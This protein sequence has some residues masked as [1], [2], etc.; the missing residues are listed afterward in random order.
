[1]RTF[2]PVDRKALEAGLKRLKLRCL[3]ETLD[4]LNE[5]ALQ[6]EPSY[7]DFIAYIVDQEVKAREETQRQK[8][9]QAARFP[10]LRTLDGFDFRF[11]T[12]VRRQTILDLAH[13]DFIKRRENVVLLGPPGVGK[14]H[15]AVALG[16]EAV[17]AGFS[18]IFN[19]VHDLVDRLYKALADDTVTAAMNRI[20][21]HDLIILDELGYLE[22]DTTGSD[23]LYQLVA[24]AYEK[25]SLIVT[26]NL[27]FGEWGELFDKPS[28][29]AAVLDRLLHYAHV[30]SLRGDSYRVRHRLA[31]PHAEGG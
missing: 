24:K 2:P 9:L 29:A 23:L 13:L 14:T 19:T 27:D 8:R 6:E 25:R 4:E 31:P 11:Q 20:L 21:R 22:L 5:L 28:T 1:M 17:N 30:I 12:S 15:L 7:L 26:S 16:I 3:R 18:V 10:F